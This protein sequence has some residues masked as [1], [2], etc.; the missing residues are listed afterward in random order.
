MFIN[1]NR[2]F[3]ILFKLIKNICLLFVAL[4]ICIIMVQRISNNKITLG[5]YGIFAVVTKSM[6]PKYNVGDIILIRRCNITDIKVGNDII[7][8]GKKGKYKNKYI[9]HQ[10]VNIKKNKF[11]TKGL[12]NVLNDPVVDSSQIY[13]VVI[14]KL[15][16]F[17]VMNKIFNNSYVFSFVIFVTIIWLLFDIYIDFIK[18]RKKK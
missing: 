13:G 8:L 1:N 18:N 15:F 4:I 16:V 2:V 10:V 5:G 7:Y 14:V 9:T 17:S 12:N 11:Y 6:S 3:I